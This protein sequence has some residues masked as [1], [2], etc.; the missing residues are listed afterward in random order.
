MGEAIVAIVGDGGDVGEVQKR[1][2]TRI[3]RLVSAPSS[4][5]IHEE[6]VAGERLVFVRASP[7]LNHFKYDVRQVADEDGTL[8]G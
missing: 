7:V 6:H 4:I 1:G 2:G 3:N 8:K 5:H